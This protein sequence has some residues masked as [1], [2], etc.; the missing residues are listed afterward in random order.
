MEQVAYFLERMMSLDEGGA[1]LLGN[2][3]ILFGSSLK[4][5]NRHLP[6]NLPL[7]L[8][9]RGKGTLRPGRRLRAQ[10]DTP[11]CNLHLALLQRLGI[12]LDSFGD[13]TGPLDGL[14]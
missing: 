3:M 1:S 10:P 9:G 12:K 6:K 2:S 14:A 4:D 5:G 7:I 8:A 11:F 13:S